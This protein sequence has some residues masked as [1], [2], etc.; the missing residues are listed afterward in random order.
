MTNPNIPGNNPNQ[1]LTPEQARDRDPAAEVIDVARDFRES[2]YISDDGSINFDTFFSDTDGFDGA[3]QLLELRDRLRTENRRD[4]SDYEN[5]FVDH[6]RIETRFYKVD[7]TVDYDALEE[8]H[9][10]QGEGV[11][12]IIDDL[13]SKLASASDRE[14]TRIEVKI[15]NLE[16]FIATDPDI[17]DNDD[18]SPE[19]KFMEAHLAAETASS[20]EKPTLDALAAD[21][22]Q[23]MRTNDKRTMK[24]TRALEVIAAYHPK[25]PNNPADLADDPQLNY[26]ASSSP[27]PP[28]PPTGGNAGGTPPAGGN[29][30]N[31][32]P[33][34]NRNNPPTGGNGGNTPPPANANS[35]Q[36]NQL[37]DEMLRQQ[38][39]DAR[40][41]IA[42]SKSQFVRNSRLGRLAIGAIA[43]SPIGNFLRNRNW[44][45]LNTQQD[46]DARQQHYN[47]LVQQN[48]RRQY[49][50]MLNDPNVG[51][52][53]KHF[54]ITKGIILEQTA[55]RNETNKEMK[56]KNAVRIGKWMRQHKF[57]T[58]GGLTVL[59]PLTGVASAAVGLSTGLALI[60]GAKTDNRFRGLRNVGESLTSTDLL[61]WARHASDTMRRLSANRGIAQTDINNAA[62]EAA[63]RTMQEEAMG[64]LDANVTREIWKRVGATMAVGG[65]AVGSAIY[66]PSTPGIDSFIQNN[67]T[68]TRTVTFG[69]ALIDL[70]IK[71]KDK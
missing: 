41:E 22:A 37:R 16:Y 55:L 34:P 64:D 54:A 42:R 25:T 3:P 26:V 12:V 62:L 7:G 69:A 61:E 48:V 13:R 43:R 17:D 6:M 8:G 10:S 5:R 4:L 32:T 38:L 63:I 18:V 24:I 46:M 51:D 66:L 39:N 52:D 40:G 29:G 31:G 57:L 56:N 36:V 11:Q 45:D 2:V 35:T 71:R 59:A 65:V 15:A 70:N 50:D 28:T 23:T 68:F 49:E 47:N 58:I 20:A 60:V 14:K 21:Y 53:I 1:P 33:P 67:S 19:A 44:V 27:T 9:A 30:G